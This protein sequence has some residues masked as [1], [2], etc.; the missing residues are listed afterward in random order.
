MQKRVAEWMGQTKVWR[1]R[2]Y[3][4]TPGQVTAAGR[5]IQPG[6]ILLERREW[7]LTNVGIPGFWT[8]AALYIGSKR[9][10]DA[11]SKEPQTAAWLRG[12]GAATL[13]GLIAQ[14]HPRAFAAL[15]HPYKDGYLPRV[16]EALAPGVCLT[17][18]EYS[19]T[20]DSLAVLR[21]QLLEVEKN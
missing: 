14:N 5:R 18:W 8:H 13:D 7:Y 16:I 9:Q 12:K 1:P 15:Q 21:P 17:S 19:A 11:L 20:C 3:L 6:D 2:S 10:R 4:I